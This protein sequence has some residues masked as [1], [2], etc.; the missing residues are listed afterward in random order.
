MSEHQSFV[1]QIRTENNRV[2]SREEFCEQFAPV[3]GF[4]DPSVSMEVMTYL[5]NEPLPPDSPPEFLALGQSLRWLET[6]AH[7]CTHW[8][9]LEAAAATKLSPRSM[10]LRTESMRTEEDKSLRCAIQR[11]LGILKQNE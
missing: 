6:W 5:S 11:R 8:Q 2:F 10:A 4:M 3:L 7:R 9:D 1:S